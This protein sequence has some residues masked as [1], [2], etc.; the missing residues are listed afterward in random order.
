MLTLKVLRTALPLAVLH[1]TGYLATAVATLSDDPLDS[2]VVQLAEPV[3]SAVLSAVLLKSVFSWK[4][5]LLPV[6]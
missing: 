5:R 4:V 2:Q 6:K 1:I 3:F